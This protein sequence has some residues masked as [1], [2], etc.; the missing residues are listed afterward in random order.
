MP[1]PLPMFFFENRFHPCSA[2]I[3]PSFFF[4]SM[5]IMVT[6]IPSLIFLTHAYTYADSQTPM[7]CTAISLCL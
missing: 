3:D 4:V 5:T 6:L 7:T 1:V 2:R